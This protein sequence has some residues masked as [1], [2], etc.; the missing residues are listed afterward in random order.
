MTEQAGQRHAVDGTGIGGFRRMAVEMR[1]DPEQ[2]RRLAEM[3]CEA[4]PGADGDR[5]IAADDHRK[6]V[7]GQ[8]RG[9]FVGE[10]A[11]EFG[12][13]LHRRLAAAR[14]RR[15]QRP[16]PVELL[17]SGQFMPGLRMMKSDRPVLTG[18]V[19]C[20]QTAGRTGDADTGTGLVAKWAHVRIA[21]S[22]RRQQQPE[23]RFTRVFPAPSGH[24][25]GTVARPDALPK[26]RDNSDRDWP[27]TVRSHRPSTRYPTAS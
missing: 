20:T 13:A 7:V 6:A 10:M 14:R 21:G 5:V 24:R 4:A 17:M 11:A 23:T 26:R 19:L 9:H 18:L 25:Y 2:P 12:N 22:T 8:R 15:V 27:R 16:P 3:T 1:V